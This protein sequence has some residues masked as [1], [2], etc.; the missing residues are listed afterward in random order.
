MSTKHHNAELL[1][2]QLN[3]NDENE[4]KENYSNKKIVDRKP[5]EG[6]PFTIITKMNDG[7][8]DGY[9]GDI[10]FGTLGRF[11]ITENK[12]SQEE[13]KH[14]LTT[15]SYDLILKMMAIII[16]EE[17]KRQIEL[18]HSSK[19]PDHAPTDTTE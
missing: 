10:S 15:M 5:L 4:H 13:V 7:T 1:H 3:V 18:A 11:R 12:K 19:T 8:L 9:E 14:E 2:T 17:V 16:P 6:T